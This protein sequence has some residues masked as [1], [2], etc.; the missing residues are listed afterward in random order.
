MKAFLR[1]QVRRLSC[2]VR[3]RTLVLAYHHVREP[4]RTTPGV[5]TPPAMFAAHMEYLVRR[6]LVVSM[7]RLL[8]DLRDLGPADGRP[9]RR[10]LRRRRFGHLGHRLPDFARPGSLGDGV[11]PDGADRRPTALLV[12]PALP[13]ERGGEGEGRRS[14]PPV[15]GPG[16]WPSRLPA[17]RWDAV[18]WLD[19][20][21]REAALERAAELL[22]LDDLDDGPTPMTRTNSPRWAATAS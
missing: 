2:L 16:G 11:R 6:R 5:T 12:E 22:G 15:R 4:G 21:R 7:D 13:A 17:D 20:P 8:A 19:E 14:R 1:S 10:H 3:P 18:R 9:S